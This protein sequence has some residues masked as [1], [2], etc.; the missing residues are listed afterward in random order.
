MSVRGP[1]P[2]ITD[3]HS[4]PTSSVRRRHNSRHRLTFWAIPIVAVGLAFGWHSVFVEHALF[5][6]ITALVT[7]GGAYAVL[8]FVAQ[9]AVTVYGWLMPGEW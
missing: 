6:S 3:D 5:F 7:F 1:P 4:T 2:L 9:R 8:A